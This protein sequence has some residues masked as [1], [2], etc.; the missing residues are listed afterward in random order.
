MLEQVLSLCNVY[1][2]KWATLQSRG[3]GE[4]PTISSAGWAGGGPIDLF[5][6]S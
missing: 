5:S 2:K 6:R 3:G 4:S 1:E